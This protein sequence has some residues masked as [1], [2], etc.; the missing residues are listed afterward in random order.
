MT[1]TAEPEKLTQTCHHCGNPTNDPRV[2]REEHGGSGAGHTL[3]ACPIHVS[4]YPPFVSPLD[5]IDAARR[6]RKAHG[7]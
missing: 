6:Y 5:L 3:Y 7:S 4:L 1:A 2:I